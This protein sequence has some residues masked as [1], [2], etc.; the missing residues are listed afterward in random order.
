MT[1]WACV[2]AVIL[3]LT[4]VVAGCSGRWQSGQG[5]RLPEGNIGAGRQAFLDLQCH[6]CHRV[7]GERLPPSTHPAVALGGQVT[8][9]P[10]VGQLTT[11]VINPSAH[12]ATGYPREQIVVD[13]HS[14]MPDL[15]E[16]MT[17]RQLTH[18]VAFLHSHYDAVLP[19]H[20]VS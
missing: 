11:D 6:T 10:T 17:V 9:V 8:V 5:F 19:P 3:I 2:A 16:R 12:L 4:L 15:T 13:G 18:I 14:R 7:K 20:P 1:R